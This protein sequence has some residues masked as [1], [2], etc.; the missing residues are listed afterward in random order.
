MKAGAHV[1]DEKGCLHT[2]VL[3]HSPDILKALI[4]A[5]V[6]DNPNENY[7]GNTVLDYV[8]KLYGRDKSTKS[9]DCCE[10]LI[11]HTLEKNSQ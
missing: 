5:G 6:N 7:G 9:K 8:T 3:T 4:K 10:I 1:Q 2:C 11:E